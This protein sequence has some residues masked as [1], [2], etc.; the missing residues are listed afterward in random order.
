M[1]MGT[2]EDI[3]ILVCIISQN[4]NAF[5][6]SAIDKNPMEYFEKMTNSERCDFVALINAFKSR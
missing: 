5:K 2:F 1:L 3:L 4:K 6:K